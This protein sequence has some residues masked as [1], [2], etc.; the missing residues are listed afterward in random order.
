MLI[1]STF[2]ASS[3]ISPPRY[4]LSTFQYFYPLI[5]SL[6]AHSEPFHLYRHLRYTVFHIYESYSTAVDAPSSLFTIGQDTFLYL[7]F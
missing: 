7:I 5:P 1:F 4:Q 3:E 2:S 6:A